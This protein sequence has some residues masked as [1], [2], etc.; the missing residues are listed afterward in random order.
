MP[1][2]NRSPFSGEARVRSSR[3][4][5]SSS[6]SFSRAPLRKSKRDHTVARKG[7]R[8]ERRRLTEEQDGKRESRSESTIANR[9]TKERPKN[10]TKG[11]TKEK[12]KDKGIDRERERDKTKKQEK[13]EH[14]KDNQ[15]RKHRKRH[16]E[17][18]RE[19][20]DDKVVKEKMSRRRDRG[21]EK[22]KHSSS[23]GAA[24][25]RKVA[26]SRSGSID[27]C[28]GSNTS[29]SHSSDG[30]NHSEPRRKQQHV[31]IGGS[32]PR[33]GGEP[34]A[35]GP[36]KPTSNVQSDDIAMFGPEKPTE[37]FGPQ[38]PS[39]DPSGSSAASAV[40]AKSFAGASVRRGGVNPLPASMCIAAEETTDR[41]I[42]LWGGK[43]KRPDG[44]EEPLKG[45]GKGRGGMYD[46]AFVFGRRK[47]R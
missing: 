47:T 8:N 30:I 11:S 35:F 18:L 25:T 2:D 28:S 7:S 6:R 13:N 44:A 39:M 45:S 37:V 29:G 40:L 1:R 19:F 16:S 10:R 15:Q 43:V 9:K 21:E 14:Q 20:D 24:K 5:S 41:N 23:K 34:L 33:A 4:V 12:Q 22:G 32:F 36:Q 3:C 38:K 42:S 26:S 17:T 27:S 46:K 31:G